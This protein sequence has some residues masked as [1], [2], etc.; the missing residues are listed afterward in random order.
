MEY[1]KSIKGLND[2]IIAGD[3]NQDIAVKEV[4]EFFDKLGV[5]DIHQ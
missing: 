5:R 2:I 1:C 3:L 4:K